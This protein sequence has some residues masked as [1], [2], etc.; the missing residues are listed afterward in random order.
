MHEFFE[1]KALTN[2]HDCLSCVKSQ[3]FIRRMRVASMGG[4]IDESEKYLFGL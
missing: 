3:L 2:A 4:K 1:L